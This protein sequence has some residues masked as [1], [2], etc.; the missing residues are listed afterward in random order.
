[1][2][3]GVTGARCELG[4]ALLARRDLPPASRVRFDLSGLAANT[5]LHDGHAWKD[6]ARTAPAGTRRAV[7][8]AREDGAR[9]LVRASFAF[10]R[11]LPARDP[12]RS[13]ALAALECED[14]AREGAVP[15]C[16]VRLGYLYGPA[17]RDLLAYRKA[18][19]LG[20][21]YWSGAGRVLQDHLHVE[22]AA[23]ALAAAAKRARAGGLYYATDGHPRSFRDFMDHFAR[24]VGRRFPLHLPR[25]SKPLMLAVVREEHMQQVE[26][27]VPARA[28]RPPVP[29]WRP[30]HRDAHAALDA[31][32]AGWKA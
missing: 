23:S 22:D 12:L 11:D 1:M 5:L 19:R 16:I 30:A 20:R 29:G 21:P 13:M 27:G 31:I 3:P 25:L 32:V 8:A 7:C 9:L 14:I 24:R 4:A 2:T 18:F 17:S 15:A 6:F 10:A 26:H 28:P